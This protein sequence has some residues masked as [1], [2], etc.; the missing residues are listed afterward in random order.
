MIMFHLPNE[1]LHTCSHGNNVL[2]SKLTGTKSSPWLPQG[3]KNPIYGGFL[4]R[5]FIYKYPAANI[6]TTIFW[7]PIRAF[8][9]TSMGTFYKTRG[10]GWVNQKPPLTIHVYNYW[11]YI[12]CITLHTHF[13]ITHAC[14]TSSLYCAFP[15]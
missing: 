9:E 4:C 2:I 12:N 1:Y 8:K 3:G 5:P 10:G 6:V 14:Y 7:W 13:I 15:I 11:L